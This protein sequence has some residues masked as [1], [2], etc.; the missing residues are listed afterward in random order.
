MQ[1]RSSS[2]VFLGLV[3]A[4]AL[5]AVACAGPHSGPSSG[6][7]G[8]GGSTGSGSGTGSGD[9]TGGNGTGSGGSAG[10]GGGG[11]GGGTTTPP[12]G[13]MGTTAKTLGCNAY[14]QCLLNAMSDTDA[15]A[16]DNAA[17]DSAT[18]DL[19]AIDQCVGNYCLGMNGGTAR[20]KTDATTGDL[21]NLDGT[22]AFDPNTGAPMGDC[23]ACLDNGEAGLWGEQCMPAN[24]AACNT[25]ACASQT[26]TCKAD[27]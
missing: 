15:T 20:C 27:M 12:T 2:S 26:A 18:A 9:G 23:G 19:D 4:T 1:M 5:V 25:S 8:S 6:P 16:C 22:A 10:T 24:D 3:T 13:D 21:T 7:T 11:G 14:V 17:K